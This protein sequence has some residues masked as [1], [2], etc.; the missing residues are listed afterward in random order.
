M[1]YTWQRNLYNVVLVGLI[2]QSSIHE[3]LS[4]YF[5]CRLRKYRLAVIND[6]YTHQPPSNVD[7]YLAC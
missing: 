2:L 7:E 3:M 1:V 5:S 6:Q 4:G